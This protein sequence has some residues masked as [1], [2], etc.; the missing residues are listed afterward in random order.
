M[1]TGIERRL[2]PEE[3]ELSKKR[4]ELALL[5]AQ[6]TEREL[7]LANRR[8]EL[9]AFEGRY[10]RQVGV[11][12]AELDD[13]TAK[14]AE[15]VA[16]ENGTDEAR[17]AATQARAQAAESGAASH[18]ERCR[19]KGICPIAGTQESLSGGGEAGSPRPCY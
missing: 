7:Y 6:L 9:T 13:W 16:D 10:L 1:T 19:V 17:S 14:I 18:S 12:Y 4:D 3:E 15:L 11:L 8:A 2:S 5:E